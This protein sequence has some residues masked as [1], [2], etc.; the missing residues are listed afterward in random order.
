MFSSMRCR[1]RYWL[2]APVLP[3]FTAALIAERDDLELAIVVV[4]TRDRMPFVDIDRTAAIET[5]G[6]GGRILSDL[7]TPSH[8]LLLGMLLPGTAWMVG[9]W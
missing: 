3:V 7:L 1:P 9:S 6:G 8:Y 4:V 2:S 5:F